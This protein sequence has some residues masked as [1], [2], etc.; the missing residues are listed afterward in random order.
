MLRD[1]G[2][3]RFAASM[4]RS[5]RAVIV[6]ASKPATAF[7]QQASWPARLRIDASA[8]NAKPLQG[9]MARADRPSGPSNT[10]T[11]VN[12]FTAEPGRRRRRLLF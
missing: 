9:I 12:G 7:P 5:Q 4:N 11:T 8:P 3:S 6:R 10:K 2:L 1:Q